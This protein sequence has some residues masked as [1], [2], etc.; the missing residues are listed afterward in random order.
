[1]IRIALMLCLA[2]PAMARA[3]G[4]EKLSEKDGVLVE[5]RSVPGSAYFEVRAT[6]RCPLPPAV[7]YATLWKHDEYMQFMPH[8]KSLQ[9]LKDEGNYRFVYEQVS[10]PVVA[11]RDYTVRLTKLVDPES[12]TY[13]TVFESATDV[14][15]PENSKFVRVHKIKGSWTLTPLD[16]GKA[17]SL[18]YLAYSEPGGSLP[19]WLVNSAQKD[20]PRDVVLAVIK[21]AMK[22]AQATQAQTG[23]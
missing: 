3:E 11:D 22:N 6:G 1:M 4:W 10:M 15:P 18:T 2:L 17:S 9:I 7:V 12:Q 16:G 23:Q 14:G 8:L 20:A 19:T 5:R 21:R 13:Q